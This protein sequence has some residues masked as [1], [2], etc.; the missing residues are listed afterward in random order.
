MRQGWKPNG[1]DNLL[2][3]FPLVRN[4]LRETTARPDAQRSPDVPRETLR[5]ALRHPNH[6]LTYRIHLTQREPCE[7]SVGL[8]TVR[9]SL[10]RVVVAVGLPV[11]DSH[12]NMGNYVA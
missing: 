2:A 10:H 9:V 7:L 4:E 3:P 6:R 11:R 8:L 1:G 12:V 5:H